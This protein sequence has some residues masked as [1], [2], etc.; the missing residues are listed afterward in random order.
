M[1]PKFSYKRA[2][3]NFDQ[4]AEGRIFLRLL[5]IIVFKRSTVTVLSTLF[6]AIEIV[7]FV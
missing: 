1:W 6:C 3:I 7:G 5:H 4:H 2:N